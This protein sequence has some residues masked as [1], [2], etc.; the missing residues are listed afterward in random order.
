MQIMTRDFTR[1]Q[2][3]INTRCAVA[4]P[5]LLLEKGIDPKLVWWIHRCTPVQAIIVCTNHI[6]QYLA[7][8]GVHFG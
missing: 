2:N 6:V 3:S 1:S 5:E 7:N 8:F 4:D